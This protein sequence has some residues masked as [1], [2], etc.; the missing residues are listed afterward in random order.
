MAWISFE[1]NF[2]D[3]ILC[4]AVNLG[5]IVTLTFAINLQVIDFERSSVDDLTGTTC[6]LNGN[7]KKGMHIR[8]TEQVANDI[9][10]REWPYCT[11]R[12]ADG[13]PMWRLLSQLL[14]NIF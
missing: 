8:D 14:L 10:S 3:G 4:S 7:I 1:Q 13:R 9:R 12:L 11:L 2:L 5:D 6:G